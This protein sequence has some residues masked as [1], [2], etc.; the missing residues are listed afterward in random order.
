MELSS[1]WL[2]V[3]EAVESKLV[4]TVSRQDNVMLTQPSVML[5][6]ELTGVLKGMLTISHQ[7]T[8]VFVLRNSVA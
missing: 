7:L 6:A 3:Q 8:K 5:A 4:D 1:D 2:E